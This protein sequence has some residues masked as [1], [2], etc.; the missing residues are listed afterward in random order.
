MRFPQSP[1]ANVGII[2]SNWSQRLTCKLYPFHNPSIDLSFD[3]VTVQT[4]TASQSCPHRRLPSCP[5]RTCVSAALKYRPC[6]RIARGRYDVIRGSCVLPTLIFRS[7]ISSLRAMWSLPITSS[8]SSDSRVK[9]QVVPLS[10]AEPLSISAQWTPHEP[11]SRSGGYGEF[12][13]LAYNAM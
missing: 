2:I 10:P 8:F 9:L 5:G 4:Q 11:G 12:H 6:H 13:L 3:A 7:P 1:Q